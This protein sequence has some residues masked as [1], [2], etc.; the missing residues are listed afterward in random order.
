[1][2]DIPEWWVDELLDGLIACAI[3]T[4]SSEYN[5]DDDEYEPG[6]ILSYMDK[7][8]FAPSALAFLRD[9]C[10]KFAEAFPEFC[11]DPDAFRVSAYEPTCEILEYVGHDLWLTSG[12]HGAGFWDGDWE[13]SIGD[14]LSEWC[15]KQGNIEIYLGDDKLIYVSGEENHGGEAE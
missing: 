7:D 1:M 5:E 13:E 8:N 3:F 9:Y 10:R 6:D 2:N 14:K 12:G 4:D 15:R 11:S